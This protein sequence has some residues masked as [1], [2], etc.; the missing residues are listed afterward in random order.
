MG[1]VNIWNMV[2]PCLHSLARWPAF[3][4]KENSKVKGSSD[5]ETG[6][7]DGLTHPLGESGLRAGE[8]D[9]C[10][11]AEL[12]SHQSFGEGLK[13]PLS[14][15]CDPYRLWQVS[16][17]LVGSVGIWVGGCGRKG[18][19]LLLTSLSP[20]PFS[21]SP[22]LAVSLPPPSASA[23]SLPHSHYQMKYSTS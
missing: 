8:G 4:R 6:W 2:L 21:C 14:I 22:N 15:H 20:S 10:L 7:G 16:M 18:S 11:S 17:V 9:S 5:K 19:S 12:V 13:L 23:D 1:A 3:G